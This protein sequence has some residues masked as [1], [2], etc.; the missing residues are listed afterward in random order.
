M[1]TTEYER[2]VHDRA[3]KVRRMTDQQ[4]CDYLEL[5]YE[6]GVDAG[7]LEGGPAPVP[8]PSDGVCLFIAYL[9]GRVG[10]RNG[11]GRGTILQLR[12][13]LARAVET[14]VFRDK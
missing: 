14:G 5:Q 1:M 11:I 4:L 3:A 9:E 7:R 6:R 8:V 10:T 12:R 2:R 13:E